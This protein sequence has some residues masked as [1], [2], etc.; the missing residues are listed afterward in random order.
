M[1]RLEIPIE[2]TDTLKSIGKALTIAQDEGDI[3]LIVGEAGTG[4]TTAL[5]SYEKESKSAVLIEVDSSFTKNALISAIARKLNLDTRGSMRVITE[6][7]V[8]AL[9]GR[10]TLLMI[11]EAEYLSD[12]AL[13]LLRR[14]INDKTGTG[15]ALF[16]LPALHYKLENRRN[17]HHQLTSRVGVFLEVKR[18]S[19]QDA[20]KLLSSVWRNLSKTVIDAFVKASKGSVRTLTKLMTRVHQTMVINHLSEVDADVVE[21][22]GEMLMEC[23]SL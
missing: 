20:R 17:D 2:E 5:R 10:D 16:G 8:N 12:G 15:V 1:E 22:A 19:T 18:M 3:A 4:K 7:I 23:I 9:K 21:A 11:D 13:E 6:R 14:V